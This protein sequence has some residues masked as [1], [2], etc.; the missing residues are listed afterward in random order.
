MALGIG[1]LGFLFLV[2]ADVA[3]RFGLWGEFAYALVLVTVSCALLAR[4]IPHTWWKGQGL[5]PPS[6]DE[7]MRPGSD[8]A[9]PSRQ[10][11]EQ[12]LTHETRQHPATVTR[13]RRWGG[14]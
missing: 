6:L 3:T 4:A 1:M 10:P 11:D 2:A 5:S 8:T 7:A 14:V 9:D 12:T 13:R